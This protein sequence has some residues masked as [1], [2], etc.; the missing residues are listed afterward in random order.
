MTTGE[1][2]FDRWRRT[3]E[4]AAASAGEARVRVI[5]D[6][7]TAL[8]VL[9]RR[10]RI[11]LLVVGLLPLTP[12]LVLAIEGLA[13]G[14]RGGLFIVLLALAGAWPGLWVL[15]RRRRL[16]RVVE[17]VDELAA[18]LA[19]AYDVA[20]AW[21]KAGDALQRVR[22][23]GPGLRGAGRAARGVWAGVQLTKELFDRFSDLP[24]VAPFL[25]IRLQFTGYLCLA[26]AVATVVL[27]V[28][29]VATTLVLAADAVT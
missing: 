25:P 18:E 29:V 16:V 15:W 21:G 23:A 6:L 11:P 9:V 3:A 5:R 10:V 4:T 22:S 19:Q 8:A 17:P 12:A 24:R 1:S 28:L 27:I 14:G 26:S 13:V 20:G 2:R 7:A